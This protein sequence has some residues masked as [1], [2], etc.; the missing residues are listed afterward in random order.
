[1]TETVIVEN[2]MM[3]RLAS[4]QVVVNLR[5][6]PPAQQAQKMALALETFRAYGWAI[7]DRRK[8]EGQQR[9]E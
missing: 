3:A 6:V 8:D 7:E 9:E 2:D 1:M 4:G 5:R